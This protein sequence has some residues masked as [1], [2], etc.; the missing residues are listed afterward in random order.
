M[1]AFRRIAIAIAA[2]VV[3]AAAAAPSAAPDRRSDI[4]A[5]GRELAEIA[6]R[7]SEECFER[8]RGYD[9]RISDAEQGVLFKAEAFA[10]GCRLFGRLTGESSG[11]FGDTHVR[12]NLFTAFGIVARSL[13][14]LDAEMSRGGVRPYEVRNAR[15]I[16]R[17]MEGA[18]R[19]WPS[20]DN[21]AYLDGRYVKAGDASVWL[22]EKRSTG[23]YVRR[24]FR[25]LESLWRYNYDR[26]RGTNPWKFLVEVPEGT[27]RGLEEGPMVD[28]TFDGRMIIE[29]SD[30]PNRPVFRI[31]GGRRRALTGPRV[32]E[33]LGGWKAVFEVPAEVIAAY[34]AGPEI[35]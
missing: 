10:A 18:F 16:L 26:K 34:P 32:V 9:G 7:M 28:L 3:T 6:G 31:E 19:E 11:A 23:V 14:D 4:A 30:R 15:T 5:L 12:T 20:P 21:L 8:F 29:Q 27:L 17:R 13:D 22:I 2:V 24:A 33:R 1:P 25:S 35:D